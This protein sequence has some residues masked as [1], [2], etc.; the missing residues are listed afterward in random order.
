M[1]GLQSLVRLAQ[2]K[3]EEKRR[4]AAQLEMLRAE[5]HQQQQRLAAEMA[6]E[7][8][9]APKG[10]TGFAYAN[11]IGAA[12]QRRTTLEESLADV[13]GKILAA[14]E[15]IAEAFAEVKRYEQVAESRAR[16]AAA[17]EAQRTQSEL[18]EVGLQ[19]FRRRTAGEAN[20]K[21]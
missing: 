20:D 12:L 1:K 2:W 14:Q 17:L 7:Q 4:Q 9:F 13:A 6:H 18:D 5:L 8:E 15:E 16:R 11:F 21:A 19:G 3:L 10:E